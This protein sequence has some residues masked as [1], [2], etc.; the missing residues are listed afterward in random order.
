M[1]SSW[2]W[3][4]LSLCPTGLTPWSP[5]SNDLA[6]CFQQLFL[7]LPALSIFAIS[8]SYFCGRVLYQVI[9]SKTQIRLLYLRI[10]AILCL[11]IISMC[12]LVYMLF[13]YK[14]NIW[15]IDILIGCT[16]ILAY[17]IHFGE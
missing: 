1:N 10:T 8:S 7:Q 6:P 17:T 12:Q 5:H 14:E 11:S 13:I 3:D 15:P 9:R 16:E 2:N 4:W